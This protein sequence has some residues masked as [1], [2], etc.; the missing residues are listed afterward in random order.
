MKSIFNV[1]GN[2]EIINRV[3]QLSAITT[4]LWGKMTTAQM[5]AHC[6][7]S[8]NMAFGNAKKRRH[9]MGVV[10]GNIGKKRLL[11][12]P[13]LD[14]NIPTF[15]NFEITDRRNFEEEKEK[16]KKLIQQA[17]IK[18]ESGLV[19]Y[20]HPYLKTFKPGEWEQLN[21]KHLDHHLRQFG[22]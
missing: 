17:L 10:F 5:L 1:E 18:G 3:D 2:A 6:Q 21:W 8:M 16:F 13:F 22:V 15:K 19:K 14:K 7:A 9:W 20:P 4:P 12:A 11:K